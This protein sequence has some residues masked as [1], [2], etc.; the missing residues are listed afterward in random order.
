MS[1]EATDAAAALRDYAARHGLMYFEHWSLPEATQLLHHG[2]M[3]EVPSVAIG[4]LP[5]ALAVGVTAAL[6]ATVGALFLV[7]FTTPGTWKTR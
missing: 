6:V 2:F 7:V 3:R 5:A 4:N 1:Q